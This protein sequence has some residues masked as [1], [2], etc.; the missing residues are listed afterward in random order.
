MPDIDEEIRLA[1]DEVRDALGRAEALIASHC[2]GPHL[3]V[4]HRDHRPPW[5]DECRRTA[6]GHKI[7]RHTHA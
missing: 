3:Y 4:Q 2:P 6:I 1:I 7:P 5:C